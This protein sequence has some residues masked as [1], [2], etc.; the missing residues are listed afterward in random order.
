MRSMRREHGV[1]IFHGQSPRCLCLV[2]MIVRYKSF[3]FM[4]FNCGIITLIACEEH[5]HVHRVDGGCYNL[6]PEMG[7]F[8]FTRTIVVKILKSNPLSVFHMFVFSPC[9]LW[10]LSRLSIS[11]WFSSGAHVPQEKALC[12]LD[13]FMFPLKKKHCVHS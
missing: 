6:L 2:A 12:A 5:I 8:G 1:L 7:K 11:P 3:M 13:A 4:I 10:W 9:K